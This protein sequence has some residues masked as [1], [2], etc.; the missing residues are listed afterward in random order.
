MYTVNMCLLHLSKFNFQT[1]SL[2]LLL[3]YI[4]N[5]SLRLKFTMNTQQCTDAEATGLKATGDFLM[6]FLHT[7]PVWWNKLTLLCNDKYYLKNVSN[8]IAQEVEWFFN[9]TFVYEAS[10]LKLR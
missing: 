10:I 3:N 8:V 7:A 2:M 1:N 6:D 5:A 4:L 9:A